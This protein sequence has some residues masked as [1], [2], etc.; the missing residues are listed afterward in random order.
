MS[1][2]DPAEKALSIDI[3]RVEIV[4]DEDHPERVEIYML[5]DLGNRVEGGTFK[6]SDFMDAVLE[7]YNR[8]Y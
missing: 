8:N 7:F 5:D 2:N 6:K 4:I 3:E 1:L